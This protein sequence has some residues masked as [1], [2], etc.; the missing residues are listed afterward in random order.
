MARH[1]FFGGNTPNG[2]YGRFGDILFLEEA[3]KIIY[4]K[5]S[6]GSGKST[7]MR[8]VA[9]TFEEKESRLIIF[10]ARIMLRI[11][12]VFVFVRRV[13]AWW[14]RRHLMFAIHPC[15]L[16]LMRY[17][18]LQILSIGIMYRSMLGSF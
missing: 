18:I 17:S 16:L 10:I 6:S 2:F 9:A 5:G 8:K 4:L 1:M 15:Q 11:W 7:L 12:M 13:S 3:K 14:M